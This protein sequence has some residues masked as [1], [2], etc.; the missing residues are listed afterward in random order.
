MLK[1]YNVENDYIEYLRQF[2][3]RIY[4][5]RGKR[6]Y[7]GVVYT[8]NNIKY[9]VPLSSPKEKHK[10]MKNEKDFHKIKGG[11]YGA[12]NFNYMIPVNSED[13]HIIDINN[14]PDIKYRTMLQNQYFEVLK[15]KDTICSKAENLYKLVQT[16]DDELSKND[17]IIKSRCCDYVMLEEKMKEYRA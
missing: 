8:L 3:E 5:N 15:I 10:K 14:E 17:K 4:T 2:D 1:F 6:P 12:V 13:L 9:Y 7:I 11:I 16:D